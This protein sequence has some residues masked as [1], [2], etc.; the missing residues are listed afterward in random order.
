MA[1]QRKTKRKLTD[2]SFD[3]ADSHIAL[4]HKDQ[5]GPA[6]GAD[7]KLVIKNLNFSKEA[8]EKMQ[9][10]RVTLDLP[11]FLEK[12]FNIYGTNAQVL[13]RMMGYVEPENEQEEYSDDWYE[14]YIQEKLESFEILKSLKDTDSLATVLATLNEKEYLT[15]LQDQFVVEKALI[16]LDKVIPQSDSEQESDTS[17]IMHEVNEPEVSVS[18]QKIKKEKQMTKPTTETKTVTVEMVEKSMLESL[19]KSLDDQKQELQKALDTINLFEQE[20]KAQIVKSKTSQFQALIK[21]EKVLAPVLKAALALESDEDFTLFLG[22][23]TA[24]QAEVTKQKEQLEKSALFTEQGATVAEDSKE[25]ESAVA[26]ILKANKAKQT[27][28]K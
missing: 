18:K 19:Q 14:N 28:T 24:M 11:D 5:G 6:N 13:A 8:I 2:I 17:N 12:F 7:Y 10:V 1:T 23:V 21:D 4:V 26:R 3:G 20:K 9:Q 15:M 16:E 25:K 27:E 22:A